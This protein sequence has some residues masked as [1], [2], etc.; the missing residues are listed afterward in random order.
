MIFVRGRRVH[1]PETANQSHT[2]H[3][4]CRS[5]TEAEAIRVDLIQRGFPRCDHNG[6]SRGAPHYSAPLMNRYA[7]FN[8]RG[9]TAIGGATALAAGSLFS[10]A[11]Y[12]AASFFAPASFACSSSNHS[13]LATVPRK[14]T[15]LK[16]F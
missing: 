5:M 8:S 1:T 15:Y 10:A 7:A 6:S 16:F 13:P 2:L 3:I 14:S 12:F 11:A 4:A 9:A